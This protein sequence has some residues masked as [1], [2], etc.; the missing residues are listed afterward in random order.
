MS[1]PRPHAKPLDLFG[2]PLAG[3]RLVEASAGTGKTWTIAGLFLRLVVESGVPVDRIL[4]V[5]YT[6]AA[7]AEL[8]ERIRARLVDLRELL[9]GGTCAEPMLE[10]LL[11]RLT[12]RDL[13]LRRVDA[14]VLGFDTAAV[15]TIHGFCQRALAEHAFASRVPFE[16]DLV[17]DPSARLR[18]VVQDFWRRELHDAEPALLRRLLAAGDSPETWL[19]FARAW[20][21]RPHVVVDAPLPGDAGALAARVERAFHALRKAWDRD[22]VVALLGAGALHG[23]SYS[24]VIIAR[25]CDEVERWLAADL[26][27]LAFSNDTRKLT[28]TVLAGKTR[29]NA[30][31][32]THPVFDACAELA[33]ALQAQERDFACQRGA[34]RARL[35]V[36]A[37]EA[38]ETLKRE[39]REHS[40]DDLLLDLGRALEGP[41]GEALATLLRERYPAALVD[42]FQDTD[43]VQYGILRR[44]YAGSDAPLYLVG[45]P[46]QAIYGFRG[47]DVFAYLAGGRD[48][49]G[50]YA[51]EFNWRS[52][53]ALIEG[54][55]ALFSARADAFVVPGIDFIEVRPAERERQ[56]LCIEGDPAAPLR[57][58][59][60]CREDTR[61]WSKGD[62]NELAARTSAAEI[63][64]VLVLAREG[65]ARIG[66]RAL[67]GGDIAVLVPTHR[68]GEL[69][70]RALRERGVA[71][72]Q[73]SGESVFASHEA[74]E[75]ERVLLALAEPAREPLLR[76]ALLTCLLGRDASDLERLSEDEGALEACMEAFDGWHR[77]WR[78][79]GLLAALRGLFESER[80]ASR[81]LALPD[82]ERRL[83][84]TLHLAEL[85]QAGP[86]TAG[87]GMTGTLKWLA[88]R[89]ET[90][91]SS[92]RAEEET[93]ELRLESDQNLVNIVTIHRSKGLEYPLVFCP[94]LWDPRESNQTPEWVSW[95]DPDADHQL[96]LDLGSTRFDTAV[97]AAAEESLAESMR[98]AYVALTRARHRCYL[99]IAECRGFER[100]AP[101]WLLDA[102]GSP[103]ATTLARLAEN[104]PDAIALEEPPASDAAVNVAVVEA[105]SL[106]A[107]TPHGAVH[108]RRQ[109]GSF[110]SLARGHAAD[111]PDHDAGVGAP[112]PSVDGTESAPREVA[113]I[114]AFPRGARAGT[115]LHAVFEALD[116][117]LAAD[118]AGGDALERLVETRLR[119]HG[120]GVEWRAV[121]AQMVRDVLNT[122]LADDGGPRL[123]EV[124]PSR[125]VHEL[126][127]HYP[128]A[129]LKAS[130]LARVLA[131]HGLPGLSGEAF[132]T[133]A[134]YLK[135]Y[136]D[137][138]FE[139]GGRWYVLDW[140]SNWLGAAPQDYAAERLDTV[141]SR[142][143][144]HLQYLLYTLA[145]HRWL[146]LTLPGYDYERHFGAVHYLFVRGMRPA[147]G[148]A[149]GVYAT[150]PARELVEELDALMRGEVTA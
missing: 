86:V 140:K 88:T 44:I 58:W 45:D 149:N 134:G 37:G 63:A 64:R 30:E 17:P 121:I 141:M 22:A 116:F 99:F 135:G 41:G 65:R 98:L 130:A 131:R 139:S 48:A 26:P 36:A 2:A 18:R 122:P 54:V 138:V 4:V 47:A 111:R 94:F 6:N 100:S 90:A 57:V 77:E 124:P 25:A 34:L 109:I 19:P 39:R 13:A 40:Y 83:T 49:D 87:L 10:T 51:L 29:K 32:P 148:A 79:R 70:R 52:D 5:T 115:C 43:P 101:G 102:A 123:A 69:V 74:A 144:Y 110:S 117:P 50:V 112:S 118:A 23:G 42:E 142:E 147:S 78:Q 71:S 35:L 119:T 114:F 82:G 113:G 108:S 14:A 61:P 33:D 137:L 91:L 68:Q 105:A 143:G 16:R 27:P 145:V 107:R 75:L 55:N 12:D 8:R 7:T 126:E 21:G 125:C 146:S 38:L 136:I 31:T 24:D 127:F 92:G 76:A 132:Q 103:V 53:P 97:A 56:P 3:Q 1:P 85:L 62:A 11:A 9:R 120:Y 15:H 28:P 104:H 129:G 73:L 59:H 106:R 95:H 81:L 80:V 84:N 66:A 133:L 46:K 93:Q 67:A 60:A 96:R 72:V 89:R 20:L 128:V 150:R